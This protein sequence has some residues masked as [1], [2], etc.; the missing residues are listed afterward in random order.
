[1]GRRGPQPKPGKRKNGRLTDQ[2]RQD[3]F[4][5]E[6]RDTMS[7]AIEARKRHHGLNE[8]RARDQ[9]GGSVVGRM[10]QSGLLTSPQYEAAMTYIR[11]VSDYHHAQ[12]G[13]KEPGAMD[14]NRVF[15]QVPTN[16]ETQ[17]ER[18]RKAK[19]R[20]EAA[21]KAIQAAQN[22]LGGRGNLWGAIDLFLIRD[23]HIYELEGELRQ[24]LNALSRHYGLMGTVAA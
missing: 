4:N 17:A 20:Y 12:G 1:M 13:P 11:Q 8:E 22:E 23:K 15:G 18:D 24:A 16:P 2:A 14:L 21:R 9:L 6:Q 7:V 19:D 5:T 3:A 10:K